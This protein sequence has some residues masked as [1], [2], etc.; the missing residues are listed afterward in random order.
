[1]YIQSLLHVQHS[2]HL[3]CQFACRHKLTWLLQQL[4][5]GQTPKVNQD[6]LCRRL[7]KDKRW[8]HKKCRWYLYLISWDV[9]Q[10]YLGVSNTRTQLV[11]SLK[12]YNHCTHRQFMGKNN[13]C[14]QKKNLLV[15]LRSMI[16]GT[17]KRIA[18]FQLLNLFNLY[19]KITKPINYI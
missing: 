2:T 7:M 9:T 6:E 3:V 19:I 15:I 10:S 4:L 11:S 18:N 12:V 16:S 13:I 8:L 17:I 1:M 14:F 5:C